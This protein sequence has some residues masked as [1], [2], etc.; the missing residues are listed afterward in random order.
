MRFLKKNSLI[1]F[2]LCWFLVNLLQ[3]GTTELLDDEAYYWVYAHFLDWGYFDHPSMIALLIKAGTF[4][5]P[6]EL[7]VRFFITV[8]STATLLIIYDLLP[9]K[10]KTLFFIITASMA[11]LQIGSIIAAPDIPLIFFTALFFWLYRRFLQQETFINA[12][13]L[14]LGMA[15]MLYSKYHG[16]LVIAFTLFS[17]FNLLKK[18][19]AYVAVIFGAILFTPHLLWQFHN[20]FPSVQYHLFERSASAYDLSFSTEYILGQ[21][22]FFGPFVGWLF[23]WMSLRYKPADRFEKALKFTL[24]GFFVF[25]F[26]STFKGRVEGNWTFPVLV[27][28]I[29]LSHQ[30]LLLHEK[31]KIFLGK[32]VPFT[33]VLVLAVRIYMAMDVSPLSWAPKDEFHQNKKWVTAIKQ[34]AGDR[35]VV[36][37]DSYQK[38]SKYWF[39]S[40]TISFSLNSYLYRRNNFNFW[41]IES[42]L[43]GKP[44]YAV[45]MQDSAWFNDVIL[46]QPEIFRGKKIDSFYSHSDIDFIIE[47]KLVVKQN[48]LSPLSA[49]IVL[50]SEKFKT[51]EA[52]VFS[53]PALYLFAKDTVAGA[54][55][56]IATPVSSGMWEIHCPE[57]I[58]LPKGDYPARFTLPTVVP[59]LPSLNSTV[60]KLKVE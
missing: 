60:Y 23:I 26:L 16:V 44:V 42:S 51:M 27:P 47:N 30:S 1:I 2:L 43:Q 8:F 12:L 15:L 57:K 13:L 28:L 54:F 25:F 41:P 6:G 20:G 21:L 24:V 14:G 45:V 55:N 46:H 33:L 38:A 56:L 34:R 19:L 52:P 10:N 11:L 58:T 53:A 48:E 59:H 7:G 22:L 40:G 36:F 9:Q 49:K 35:P 3:A 5:F 17:H 29:I 50:R 32:T 4:I 18:P 37:M 31:W 39:Y